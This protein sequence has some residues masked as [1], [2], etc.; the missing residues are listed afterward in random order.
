MISYPQRPAAEKSGMGDPLLCDFD[1]PLR[2]VYHPLGLSVEITTNS[3]GVLSAAD[4]SW[5]L[6]H[7]MFSFPP[8]RLRI[9]VLEPGDEAP[10]PVPV[11][12]SQ[13]NL[14]SL[15][16]NQN[17][18]AVCDLNQGFAFAW[19]TATAVKDRAYLRYHFLEATTLVLLMSRYLT[20]IHAACVARNGKGV[21]LCG[22][23]GAGKSSLAFA[24]ARR[25]WTYISDD[26]SCLI[27]GRADRTVVGNSHQIHLRESARH[28]FPELAQQ[29]LTRRI[30]G[31]MAIALH[32]PAMPEIV[33]APR[34]RVEYIVF[35][36]RREHALVSLTRM[37]IEQVLPHFE[38]VICYGDSSSR[39]SQRAA[40]RK[41]ATAAVFELTYRSPEDAVGRLEML[42]EDAS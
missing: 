42:I 34:A 24:C 35:L 36:N 28:L 41:L 2:Q 25:G 23:S 21:L 37:P 31:E 10:P 5:G 12:R 26:S 18:F 9:G 14:V 19:L 4:L 32:T 22:Q 8:V 27:R 6:F 29:P 33:T 40:V 3:E 1:L 20:A 15:V 39:Q 13:Q 17:N 7:K 30:N 11:Y 16:G 38:D